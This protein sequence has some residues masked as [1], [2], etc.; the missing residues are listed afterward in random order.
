M[1]VSPGFGGQKFLPEMLPKIRRLRQLYQTRRAALT[2]SSKSTAAKIVK[3]RT[4][5]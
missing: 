1:T 2:P 3:R 5:D 4:G